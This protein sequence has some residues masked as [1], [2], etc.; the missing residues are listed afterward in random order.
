MDPTTMQAGRGGGGIKIFQN[1]TTVSRGGNVHFQRGVEDLLQARTMTWWGPGQKEDLEA[2]EADLLKINA[3]LEA[4]SAGSKQAPDLR[5]LKSETM[6]R[7]DR[8][9]RD[10]QAAARSVHDAIDPEDL[11]RALC[12][13][14]IKSAVQSGDPDQLISALMDHLQAVNGRATSGDL[15]EDLGDFTEEAALQQGCSLVEYIETVDSRFSACDILLNVTDIPGVEN[16]TE[17]QGQF[18]ASFNDKLRIFMVLQ[19][20]RPETQVLRRKMEGSLDAYQLEAL[21][22]E[23]Y[24]GKL[25]TFV[26]NDQPAVT[27]AP[28]KPAIGATV[29][30][31]HVG[32]REPPRPRRDPATVKCFKCKEYGHYQADCEAELT[33]DEATA[34]APIITPAELKILRRLL[35]AAGG[36]GTAANR[37]ARGVAAA[38]RT[39]TFEAPHH[40]NLLAEISDDGSE[41]GTA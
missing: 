22:F 11:T 33:E 23:A 34:A 6:K 18:F 41:A 26:L 14:K 29:L 21:D 24:T 4:L 8:L 32:K 20:L 31:G 25:T 2:E 5:S 40:P 1:G 16:L 3:E 39:V 35:A 19:H 12:N 38:A 17:E 10:R 37:G 15:A 28:R 13:K 30:V 36:A 7:R 27:P 9:I